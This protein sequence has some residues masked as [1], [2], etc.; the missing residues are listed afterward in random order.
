MPKSIALS[1]DS[2]TYTFTY[3]RTNQVGEEVYTAKTGP[4]LG[5]MR[6]RARVQPNQAGTVNRV[7]LALDVPKVVDGDAI[8][9]GTQPVVQFTQVQSSDATVFLGSDVADRELLQ[10]L[11]V[12]LTSDASVEAMVVDG[13]NLSA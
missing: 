10:A 7:R 5:R 6:I 3:D 8:A 13:S 4:L 2:T 1:V 12:A 11:W 9:S